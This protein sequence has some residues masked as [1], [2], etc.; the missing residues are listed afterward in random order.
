M[1]F[2]FTEEQQAIFDAVAEICEDFKSTARELTRP[3]S[4]LGQYQGHEGL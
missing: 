1:D 3:E 4:T 2:S